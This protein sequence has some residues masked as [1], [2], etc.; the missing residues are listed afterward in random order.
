MSHTCTCLLFLD[1]IYRIF[2]CE[3]YPGCIDGGT[4][5]SGATLSMDDKNSTRFSVL[6]RLTYGVGWGLG[7][8]Q[9]YDLRPFYGTF[10]RRGEVSK[11]I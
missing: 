1:K 2:S 8:E 10:T 4:I 9:I 7:V 5:V 11:L 6:P 3:L